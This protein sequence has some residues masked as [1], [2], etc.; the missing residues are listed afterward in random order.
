MKTGPTFVKHP[1]YM[2][3]DA[4]QNECREQT[5]SFDTEALSFTT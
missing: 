1:L 4:K 5:A 2:M 3:E